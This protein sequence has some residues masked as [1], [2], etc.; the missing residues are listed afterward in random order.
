MIPGQFTNH[1]SN[2]NK[3]KRNT[4]TIKSRT[5]CQHPTIK[6][7]QLFH[8]L[9]RERV[10]LVPLACVRTQLLV[11]ELA[12][13]LVHHLM[14]RGKLG[15]G[16]VRAPIAAADDI[17]PAAVDILV[18]APAIVVVRLNGEASRRPVDGPSSGRLGLDIAGEG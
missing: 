7:H 11:R 13:H 4:P 14:F 2:G 3:T 17:V 18:L 15:V 16:G 6:T 12:A 9:R 8:G 10:L 1:K 5:P